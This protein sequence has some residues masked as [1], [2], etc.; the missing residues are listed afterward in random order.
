M[1]YPDN[2][3]SCNFSFCFSTTSTVRSTVLTEPTS[4]ATKATVPPTP[5]WIKRTDL[6]TYNVFMFKFL[7]SIIDFG[8]KH[9]KRNKPGP[10]DIKREVQD[11]HDSFTNYLLRSA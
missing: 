8:R 5:F 6:L 2:L 11:I 1:N 9:L 4:A 10:N 7:V 3:T